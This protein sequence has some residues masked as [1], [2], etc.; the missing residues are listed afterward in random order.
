VGGHVVKMDRLRALFE[1]LELANVQTFIASGN[2]VFD[3]AGGTAEALEERI[4]TH[5]RQA[6]GYAVA[7]FLRTPHEVA[8]AAGHR[9][10]SAA[11]HDAEGN[12][13]YIGFLRAAPG[14][15]ARERVLA[16]RTGTDD[17]HL[18]G[19]ELYWLCRTRI[20]DS[21]VTGA[22]L[23]KALGMPA[24]LRNVSTVRKLAAKHPPA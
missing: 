11:D 4:E 9:P 15:E 3:H 17:F 2:V 12:T 8:A 23:E 22:K 14:G 21:P 10:F 6:L 24:T 18:H 13:L 19:R 16:L 20:S 5:L 1:E 7:T